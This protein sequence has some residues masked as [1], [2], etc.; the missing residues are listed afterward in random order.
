MLM[1]TDRSFLESSYVE[2][3]LY[4]LCTTCFNIKKIMHSTHRVCRVIL[5]ISSNYFL[6]HHYQSVFLI[7]TRVS[8]EVGTEFVYSI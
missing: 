7:D 5:R 1:Y 2:V 4:S 3:R 8:C 6:E